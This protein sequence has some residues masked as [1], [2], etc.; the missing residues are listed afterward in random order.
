[1]GLAGLCEILKMWK[2]LDVEMKNEGLGLS[3]GF[4]RGGLQF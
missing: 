4:I 1:M 3:L 2:L